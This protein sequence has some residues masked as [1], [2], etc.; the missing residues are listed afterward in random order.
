MPIITSSRA[1]QVTYPDGVFDLDLALRW[2]HLLVNSESKSIWEIRRKLNPANLEKELAPAF[3]RLPVIEADTTGVGKPVP[4]YRN[5]LE[6]PDP[7]TSFWQESD[8]SGRVPPLTTPVHLVSGWYDFML[9]SLLQDYQTLKETDNSP[10]L[11]IGPWFHVSPGC[12]LEGVKEG[13]NWF[14][15]HI[16]GQKNRLRQ[17]AVRYFVMG[18]EEWREVK[19]WPPET[20]QTRYFLQGNKELSVEVPDPNASPDHYHYDPANPTPVLGGYSI[21]AA[22]GPKDQREIEA[23]PDVLVYTSPPL[24]QALEINGWVKLELFVKSSLEHT[25]FLG[26]LCDVYPDG[27]SINICEGLLRVKPGIGE[28][29]PDGSLKLE[30]DLLATSQ[31]FKAGHSI[32]LQVASGGHPHWNRNLGTGEPIATA[33]QMKVADQTI[34][35]DADH[36]SALIL[37]LN[38]S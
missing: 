38:F 27:R 28:V 21:S 35:H 8:D 5:W 23:R 32:R 12:F 24:N 19:S 34:F 20:R 13:I 36:P 37:P 33:T 22:A 9:R 4:F 11:T 3:M 7:D 17:K 2:I 25:D 30:I 14:D 26:R 10:Y 15:A 29:Q 31:Q 6:H 1:Y 18:A 16:K